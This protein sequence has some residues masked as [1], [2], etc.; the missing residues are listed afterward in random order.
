MGDSLQLN[1][2]WKHV[3]KRFE[4]ILHKT[5][6]LGGRPIQSGS[7]SWRPCQ[8]LICPSVAWSLMLPGRRC[9]K[10]PLRRLQLQRFQRELWRAARKTKVNE[11]LVV[12]VAASDQNTKP[13]SEVFFKIFDSKMIFSLHQIKVK[14]RI[15]LSF[16]NLGISACF[17]KL[18]GLAVVPFW[19][20]LCYSL[21][22][23]R[24]NILVDSVWLD[25]DMRG[26]GKEKQDNLA[27]Q[28]LLRGVKTDYYIVNHS[29][30]AV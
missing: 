22:V 6:F 4:I 20:H 5:S 29:C 8:H 21:W 23:V 24:Y 30:F 14:P 25:P 13:C 7:I 9:R 19:G 27:T 17:W 16:F 10:V 3:S 2:F 12:V 15:S 26:Q 1:F 18:C 28:V 11:V